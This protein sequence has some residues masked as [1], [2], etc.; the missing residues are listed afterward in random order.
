MKK[1]IPVLLAAVIIVGALSS[2]LFGGNKE[3]AEVLTQFLPG[4][5]FV[6][7]VKGA[8][9][10]LKVTPVLVLNT[11]DAKLYTRLTDEIPKIRDTIQRVLRSFD[12]ETLLSDDAMDTAKTAII[13]AVNERM[14]IDNVV[15][16]WFSEFVLQ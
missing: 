13:A 12:A 4:D 15:D 14:E 11:D 5:F 3:P 9:N 7:N 1:I 10:L 8:G 2:C 6:A 16:V